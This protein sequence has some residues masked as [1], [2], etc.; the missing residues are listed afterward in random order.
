MIA[1]IMIEI[2]NI[3]VRTMIIIMIIVVTTI[4]MIMMMMM[5]SAILCCPLPGISQRVRLRL[6]GNKKDKT[7]GWDRL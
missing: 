5:Q 6:E 7:A 1:K 2:I 3:M 4:M